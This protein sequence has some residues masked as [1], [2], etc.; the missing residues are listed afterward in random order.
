MFRAEGPFHRHFFTLYTND[1]QQLG[2]LYFDRYASQGNELYV[3]LKVVNSCLYDRSYMDIID[4]IMHQCRG[5]AR[6]TTCSAQI[7]TGRG[8]QM[9]TARSAQ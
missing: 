1:Y 2:N 7:G 5:R 4:E 8:G 6:G 9:G 3:W